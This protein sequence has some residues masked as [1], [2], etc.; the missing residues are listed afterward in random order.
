M[1]KAKKTKRSE[2][3]FKILFVSYSSESICPLELFRTSEVISMITNK[4]CGILKRY[5]L[6]LKE[7]IYLQLKQKVTFAYHSSISK[8]KAHL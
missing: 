7:I 1:I 4:T 2:Y 5:T 8:K 3:N 6:L